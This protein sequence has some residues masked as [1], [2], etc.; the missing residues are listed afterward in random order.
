[1]NLRHEFEALTREP[2]PESWIDLINR[3]NAEEDDCALKL[4]PANDI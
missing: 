1:V 4:V 2:L 3:V